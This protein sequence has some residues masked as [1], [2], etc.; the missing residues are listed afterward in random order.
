MVK[1]IS[2]GRVS[3]PDPAKYRGPVTRLTCESCGRTLQW[4]PGDPPAADGFRPSIPRTGRFLGPCATEG[5]ETVWRR[6]AMR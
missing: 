6:V 2:E 3:G 4:E 5:R 1:V